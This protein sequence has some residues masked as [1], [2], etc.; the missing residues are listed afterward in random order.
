[1]KH[2]IR[3]QFA[4]IFIALL[5]GTVGLCW[6]VNSM[7]LQKYYQKNKQEIIEESYERLNE[8][9]DTQDSESDEFNVEFAKICNTNKKYK[10]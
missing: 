5:T 1:M 10:Y 3:T 9:F 6:F 8:L 4:F 2:S 7:F